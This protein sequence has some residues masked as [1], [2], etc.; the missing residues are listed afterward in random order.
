MVPNSSQSSLGLEYF[1]NEG[2]ELWSM[3][4]V[5]LVELGRREIA[6]IGL[7]RYEEVCGGAVFRVEKAYPVYDASYHEHLSRVRTFVD[8]LENCQTIGRNGLHRYDNQDHAMYTGMLAARNLACG[9]QNDVWTVNTEQEYHEEV[10]RPAEQPDAAQAAAVVGEALS[11]VFR[12]LDAVA[13]GQASGIIGGL[14]LCLAT[15]F[16]VIKGG[17]VVGPNLSLL[18]QVFPYYDVTP[19]GIL[20][21]LAYGALTGFGIGWI[22]AW[23]RNITVMLTLAA[24]DRRVRLEMLW[25][26]LE[27]ACTGPAMRAGRNHHDEG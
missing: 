4:D 20:L 2:D 16:L 5:E 19:A 22:Y 9:E 14:L 15:L 11:N 12:R 24:M 6:K 8:G 25:K 13:L 17:P 26:G 23:L 1:C 27:S 18:S 7:A 3:P 10:R 21:G